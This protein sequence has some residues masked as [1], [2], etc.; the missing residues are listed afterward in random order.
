LLLNSKIKRRINF[1][2]ALLFLDKMLAEVQG[3]NGNNQLVVVLE[4]EIHTLAYSHKMDSS[5][6]HDVWI[7]PKEKKVPVYDFVF[8]KP[9]APPEGMEDEVIAIASKLSSENAVKHKFYPLSYYPLDATKR[10]SSNIE[11]GMNEMAITCLC[12]YLAE[13]IPQIMQGKDLQGIAFFD[14]INGSGFLTISPLDYARP[15]QANLS[16]LGIHTST[17]DAPLGSDKELSVL[18]MK[19]QEDF[20]PRV[21]ADAHYNGIL[22]M[23]IGELFQTGGRLN[24]QIAQALYEMAKQEIF[25]E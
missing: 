9:M 6:L 1:L 8:L 20:R 5:R 14:P 24:K 13:Y 12:K 22:F 23:P 7:E 2:S 15:I 25:I 10:I 16:A 3:R 17:A 4:N 18:E 19:A 11:I 21:I